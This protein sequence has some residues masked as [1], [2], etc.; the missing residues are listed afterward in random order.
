MV[1][2]SSWYRLVAVTHD[3]N[4]INDRGYPECHP[5]DVVGRT[6]ATISKTIR[7][8]WTFDETGRVHLEERHHAHDSPVVPFLLRGMIGL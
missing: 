8:D 2:G 6:S 1:A 3:D 7:L 5:R 4:D